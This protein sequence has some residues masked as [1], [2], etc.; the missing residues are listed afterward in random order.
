MGLVRVR[1]STGGTSSPA[2]INTYR[3]TLDEPF[4]PAPTVADRLTLEQ[5]ELMFCEHVTP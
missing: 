3:I 5:R 2:A 1:T 4:M